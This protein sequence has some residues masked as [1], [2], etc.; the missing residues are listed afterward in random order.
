MPVIMF[1]RSRLK[2]A[3]TGDEVKKICMHCFTKID[4]KVRTDITYLTG[5]MEVISIDKTAEN[6]CL[7][8]DTKGHFV[9]HS[10]WPI[11]VVQSEKD[12]WEHKRNPSFGDSG[13]SHLYYP[14]LFINVNYITEIDLETGKITDFFLP[15]FLTFLLLAN[16]TN[17]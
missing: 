16:A 2:Y 4:G 14:D 17:L 8:C 6:F 7:F 5:F 10:R 12:L 13:S 1:P 3:L 9:L 15:G 11:Q